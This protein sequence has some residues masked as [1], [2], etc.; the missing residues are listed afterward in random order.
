MP[1]NILVI[2]VF[3]AVLPTYTLLLGDVSG[4]PFWALVRDIIAAPTQEQ[5]NCHSPKPI[6][7]NTGDIT[8]P[9]PWQP[10]IL[11]VQ[12]LRIGQLVIA[13]VPAEFT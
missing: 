7:L 4:N 3:I 1:H 8:F 10:R 5:T 11:P 9:Y 13:G 6:L 12:L 2:V